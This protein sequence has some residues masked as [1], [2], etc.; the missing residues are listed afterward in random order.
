MHRGRR[1]TKR[2]DFEYAED[3]C[4]LPRCTTFGCFDVSRKAPSA[5]G[6]CGGSSIVLVWYQDK[7]GLPEDA[8]TLQHMAKLDFDGF[9][10][11][12]WY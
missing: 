6:D 3:W 1:V 8:H 2:E 9:L 10:H 5:D 7:F 4:I 11:N 12:W